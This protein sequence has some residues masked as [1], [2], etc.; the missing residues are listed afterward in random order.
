MCACDY[1]NLGMSIDGQDEVNS[2]HNYE[3]IVMLNA[4]NNE[5]LVEISFPSVTCPETV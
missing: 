4:N 5:K 1:A 3:G 2:L